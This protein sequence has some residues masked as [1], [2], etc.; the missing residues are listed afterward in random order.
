MPMTWLAVYAQHGSSSYGEISPARLQ[1]ILRGDAPAP[2]ERASVRQAL[3]E[4]DALTLSYP[5]AQGLADEL[6]MTLG[7]LEARCVELT[8]RT[9][10]SGS[11]TELAKKAGPSPFDPS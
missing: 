4:M 9:L 8:G 10:G 2:G 5:P 7:Q 6:G 1:D 11:H 3:L